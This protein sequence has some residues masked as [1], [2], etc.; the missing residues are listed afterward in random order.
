ME[1]PVTAQ[2]E[3]CK[4]SSQIVQKLLSEGLIPSVILSIKPDDPS[5]IHISNLPA[6]VDI[7]FLKSVIAMAFMAI[8][9]NP[10]TPVISTRIDIPTD[11]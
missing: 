11:N 8:T 3:F 10:N 6:S 1:I 2:I 9:L 5:H 4:A 7:V